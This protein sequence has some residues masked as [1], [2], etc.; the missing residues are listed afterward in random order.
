MDPPPARLCIYCRGL[1][2]T[3]L[4][5]PTLRARSDQ[6]SS[7]ASIH[8][9]SGLDEHDTQLIR[10]LQQQ[11]SSLCVRCSAWNVI[12]IFTKS[13]PLDI[14]QRR[15]TQLGQYARAMT[16]YRPSLGE[17]SQ[18][19]LTPSCPFCRL[20]YCIVSRDPGPEADVP[21]QLEP[22]RSHIQHNGWESLP[23]KWRAEGAILLGLATGSDPLASMGSPFRKGDNDIRFAMMTGPAIAMETQCAPLD[24]RTMNARPL[25]S[26]LDLSILSR[27]LEHCESKHGDYCR[28]KKPTELLT[29]RMVD[30][31]ERRVIQCPPDCDYIA[32]SYVWGGVQPA[33]GAL[34]GQFLP[35]TIEDA[36]TVTK[37]LKR[38]YLWVGLNLL[39]QLFH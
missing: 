36:I 1:E 33:S 24:R 14:L 4:P 34:E 25:N 5:C 20:L 12:D 31:Q 11:P 29:T 35:Q 2:R 27:L 17:P 9:V 6:S 15:Q 19:L 39:C 26:T 38:R 10:N 22:F 7:N 3:D 18:L 32:L 37:A 23:E 28:S 16:S 30:V 13:Q 21:L 8:L